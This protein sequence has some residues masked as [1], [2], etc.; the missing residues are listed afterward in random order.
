MDPL[1]CGLQARPNMMT[2]TSDARN[3]NRQQR[4]N[5]LAAR[6][7]WVFNSNIDPTV[8]A[9]KSK[10]IQ[11]LAL[12][13]LT[14]KRRYF[15]NIKQ[16]L[17]KSSSRFMDFLSM[18]SSRKS[19]DKGAPQAV[20]QNPKVQLPG[21]PLVV[22]AIG[23]FVSSELVCLDFSTAFWLENPNKQTAFGSSFSKRIFSPSMGPD[24]TACSL[25]V[26]RC[27]EEDEWGEE[28]YREANWPKIEAV[29]N[30]AQVVNDNVDLRVYIGAK[31]QSATIANQLM[32]SVNRYYV[33]A[34][35]ILCIIALPYN[36]SVDCNDGGRALSAAITVVEGSEKT[37]AEKAVKLGTVV[38]DA[39]SALAT[40]TEEKTAFWEPDPETRYNRPVTGT[41][42]VDA[43]DLRAEMLKQR[44]LQEIDGTARTKL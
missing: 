4:I 26:C 36:T 33:C 35:C 43:A 13:L 29:E 28:I 24:R 6:N 10:F 31:S 3:K 2:V 20:A 23:D 14:S 22:C 9:C 5:G 27:G 11:K 21:L 17:E 42:E 25:Y 1:T 38:K 41:K 44:N 30:N 15:P 8:L 34:K 39:T 40:T 7:N 16:W 37:V 18:I 32:I 12:L 19:T